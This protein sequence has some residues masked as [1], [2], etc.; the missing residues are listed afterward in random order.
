MILRL[1]LLGWLLLAAACV[2]VPT[3]PVVTLERPPSA[4]LEPLAIDETLAVLPNREGASRSAADCVRENLSAKLRRNRVLTV[5]EARDGFFPWLEP[6]RVPKNDAAARG[7]VARPAV[8]ARLRD[9]RLRYLVLVD[10]S[11]TESEGEGGEML[12]A[13]AGFGKTS[14]RAT[15]QVVDLGAACCRA[16]GAARATGIWGYAHVVI[17][18]VILL[19]SVE[20]PACE[21][22]SAALVQKLEPP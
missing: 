22:L 10:L 12:L 14:A 16:G 9:L 17:Y 11:L 8:A 20:A 7:F 3:P 13:G 5:D 6:D 4:E 2:P 21:R 15:A 1:L 18:G 19:S